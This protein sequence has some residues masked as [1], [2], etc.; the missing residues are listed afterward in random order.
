MKP[1]SDNSCKDR[2]KGLKPY[3][4][5]QSSVR[6]IL[7]DRTLEDIVENLVDGTKVWSRSP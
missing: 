3:G 4:G 5:R 1:L 6:P 7:Y 2:R